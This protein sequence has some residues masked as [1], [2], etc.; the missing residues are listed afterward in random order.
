VQYFRIG[1]VASLLNVVSVRD[2]AVSEVTFTPLLP[3]FYLY[4]LTVKA[5]ALNGKML[6][7]VVYLGKRGKLTHSFLG[8]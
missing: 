6:F 5:K 8:W 2:E 3:K 7:A 1:E 4:H